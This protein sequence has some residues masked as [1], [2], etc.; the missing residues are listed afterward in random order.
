M[1]RKKEK[2]PHNLRGSTVVASVHKHSSTK[3]HI[4]L[5]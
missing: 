4:A 2:K 5:F 3:E 1:K